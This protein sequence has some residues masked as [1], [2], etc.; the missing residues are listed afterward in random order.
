MFGLP[1]ETEI[2]EMEEKEN[3]IET[4]KKLK[5]WGYQGKMEILYTYQKTQNTFI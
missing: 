2:S 3:F 1:L 4:L 5:M